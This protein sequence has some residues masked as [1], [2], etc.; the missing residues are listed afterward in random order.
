MERRKEKAGFGLENGA[1]QRRRMIA[2]VRKDE[3]ERRSQRKVGPSEE[4]KRRLCEGIGVNI[5]T[6]ESKSS[7]KEKTGEEA[8]TEF[9]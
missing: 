8:D 1:M 5:A 9:L 4:E 6:Q 7:S 3:F 2:G